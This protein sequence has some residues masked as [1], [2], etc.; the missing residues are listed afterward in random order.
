M[1]NPS[2]GKQTTIKYY[3][4]MEKSTTN[5]RPAYAA[6]QTRVKES[7][8]ERSFLATATIPVYEETEEDW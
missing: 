7:A 8:L 3:R 6:P 2:S 5:L 1:Y 4:I